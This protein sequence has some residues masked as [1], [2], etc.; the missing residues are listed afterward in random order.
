M[1]V[2]AKAVCQYWGGDSH[3]AE[4]HHLPEIYNG[5]VREM[6]EK[7]R[8]YRWDVIIDEKYVKGGNKI[9]DKWTWDFIKLIRKNEGKPMCYVMCIGSNNVRNNPDDRE[10]LKVLKLTYQ[11]MQAIEVTRCATLCVVSPIPDGER[12][13]DARIE[14]LNKDL[15]RVC[16]IRID[17]NLDFEL[18]DWG[19]QPNDYGENDKVKYVSFTNHVL[20][21]YNNPL[22]IRFT[23]MLFKRDRIHLNRMGARRLAE[24][25]L[26]VQA[27]F[28]NRVYGFGENQVSTAKRL[29]DGYPGCTVED[30]DVALVGSID[31]FL[32]A[33]RIE[34]ETID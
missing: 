25:I 27:N 6:K 17:N 7:A 15:E 9:N 10:H 2:E 23:E 12:R 26:K 20:P 1:S 22:G 14:A 19:L 30:M 16:R 8:R 3:L 33:K 21:H 24:E 32:K 34:S 4:H 28:G 13:S 29:R 11:V 18:P 5:L 31:A